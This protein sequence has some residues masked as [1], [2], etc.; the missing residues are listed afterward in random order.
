MPKKLRKASAL[1]ISMEPNLFDELDKYAHDNFID[2]SK[3]IEHLIKKHIES[4][5][6]K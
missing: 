3:L 2:K 1:T 4:K 6:K 5:K